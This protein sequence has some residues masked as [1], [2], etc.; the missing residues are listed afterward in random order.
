VAPG[1]DGGYGD[2]EVVGEVLDCEELV[3]GVHRPDCGWRPCHPDVRNPVAD[4]VIAQD[5]SSVAAGRSGSPVIGEGD[6]NPCASGVN[7][8]FGGRVG[9]CLTLV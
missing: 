7:A 4:P 6:A 8:W 1:V 3:E 2:T 5:L 9:G